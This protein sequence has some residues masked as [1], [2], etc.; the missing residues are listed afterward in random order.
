MKSKA[1]SFIG[2]FFDVGLLDVSSREIEK[3]FESNKPADC[4]CCGGWKCCDVKSMLI[5]EYYYYYYYGY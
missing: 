3:L 1:F 2:V 4:C 5:V